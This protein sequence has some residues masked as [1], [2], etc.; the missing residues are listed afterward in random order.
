M[1]KLS[2]DL[3]EQSAQYTNPVRDRELDLRGYKI[4]VIENL[5]ATLDQFDTI[6]FSDNEIRKLDGFPLLKRLKC[7]LMSNNRIV[8]IGENL[9][10]SLP[11]LEMLVL[12]NNNIQELSDLDNLTCFKNLKY[13]SLLRNPV[14]SQ[15]NYRQYL[16]HKVSSLRVIDFQRVKQKERFEAS[17]LYK[18]KKS[19]T[20]L[21]NG[22]AAPGKIKKTFVAGEKL[23]TAEK[24]NV[25]A[26]AAS[27]PSVVS[28]K[29]EI[30]AI[31]KAIARAKTLQEVE[32]LNQ[33]LRSGQI[34]GFD[35]IKQA[36]RINNEEVEEE[37]DIEEPVQQELE[38]QEMEGKESL[39]E[40]R[41]GKTT[42]ISSRKGT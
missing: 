32:R 24:R 2:A 27:V 25:A 41:T 5:G 29:E 15:K 37:M 12:T 20:Q 30:E 19:A 23:S 14:T 31:K 3:I 11:N 33:M 7:L 28:A 13:I 38:E 4:P 6:D 36:K 21:A 35:A 17:K 16:I 1:V 40:K 22:H 18:T 9:D 34:P 26:A 10:L 42:T 39:K 8:R